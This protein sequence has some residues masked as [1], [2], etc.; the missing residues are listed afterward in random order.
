MYLEMYVWLHI[1]F[2]PNENAFNI[3]QG[4]FFVFFNYGDL[5]FWILSAAIT[6]LEFEYNS[7]DLLYKCWDLES[8][9]V[10][11]SFACDN[12]ALDHFN[13]RNL[14]VF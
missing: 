3:F 4:F 9:L 1:N 6:A 5:Y 12:G 2:S 14:R 11:Y 7:I 10:Y 13:G 8:R